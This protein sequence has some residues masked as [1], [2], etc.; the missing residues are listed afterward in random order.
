[1]LLFISMAK[2]KL[3]EGQTLENHPGLSY[4]ELEEQGY[5]PENHPWYVVNR[6][7]KMKAAEESARALKWEAALKAGIIDASDYLREQERRA[8]TLPPPELAVDARGDVV[9]PSEVPRR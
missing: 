3:H 4:Q 1:M 5:I 2:I 6:Q 8:G 7:K 9:L